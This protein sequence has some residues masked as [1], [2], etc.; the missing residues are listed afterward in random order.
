MHDVSGMS[1]TPKRIIRAAGN[2]AEVAFRYL[3][4]LFIPFGPW[5]RMPLAAKDYAGDIVDHLDGL[6]PKSILMR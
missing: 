6:L 2:R 5:H 1:V 3:L 4:R